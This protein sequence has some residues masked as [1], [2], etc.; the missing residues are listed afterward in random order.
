MNVYLSSSMSVHTPGENVID[1]FIAE[2][3]ACAVITGM[4]AS[5]RLSLFFIRE[6]VF[7]SVHVC[8]HVTIDLLTIDMS[9]ILLK[10]RPQCIFMQKHSQHKYAPYFMYMHTHM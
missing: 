7:V 2:V 9:D 8:K 4:N 6:F 3:T 10:G 1:H 5:E